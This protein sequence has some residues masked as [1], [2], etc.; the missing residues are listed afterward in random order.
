MRRG[1]YASFLPQLEQATGLRLVNLLTRRQLLKE[2]KNDVLSLRVQSNVTVAGFP[3]KPGHYRAVLLPAIALGDAAGENDRNRGEL[4]FIAGEKLHPDRI[5]A[6]VPVEIEA[7]DPSAPR[8]LCREA[9]G[10]LSLTEVRMGAKA[11]RIRTEAS[12]PEEG[13]PAG[14][15]ASCAAWSAR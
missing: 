5:V 12:V 10:Q 11:L 8:T 4:Y 14:F 1:E 13:R 2:A 6:A 3:L 15:E 7:A 9:D